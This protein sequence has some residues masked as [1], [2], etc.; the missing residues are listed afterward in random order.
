MKPN[1]ANRGHLS[2]ATVISLAAAAS[3][4]TLFAAA[5][6][7][8]GNLTP[9]NALKAFETEPGFAVTLVAA[10]PLTI[11][12]VALAFDERG[13]LFV[14]EGRDYP[15]GSPD[16]RP[17]GV[18][19]ML[20]D[21]DGDGR[22]DKRTDFATGIKFPN[23]VMCWRG[24]VIVTAAPDVWW[25]RDTND[26][27]KADVKELLLTGFDT[28]STSQLR[29]NDPT[30]G[31]DGWV[32]IAGGLRG[33]K[34]YSPKR[35]GVII[36][37]DKGDLRFKPDTGEMELTEGKSQFGL[38]FDD[39]GNRFAYMNRIQS[40]HAP[41]AFRYVARNP[42]LT[43]PG[44]LQSCPE[45][46]EN[47]LMTRY[48]AGA[49]RYYPI[50]D[51]LTTADSHFGTYSAACAVHVYRGDA[52]PEPYRGAAFSCDPTG[53][54]VRGDRLEK[55]GGTFAARRI[56]EG[57]EALRSR[58]NWFRPV[59]IA[60]GPDGALYIADMYRKVIEHP[61]YLP[62]DVRKHVDFE[63]G[64]DK[65]RI[66]KL[67]SISNTQR[68]TFKAIGSNVHALVAEL[69]S[70][71]PWRRD[72]AFRFLVERNDPSTAALLRKSLRASD[73]SG[74]AVVKLRLLEFAGAMDE[75]TLLLAL[76]HPQP[77]VRQNAVRIAEPSLARN[78]SLHDLVLKLADDPDPHVRFQV[79]LSLGEARSAE[80]VPALARIAA[81]QESDLWTRA[82]ILSALPARTNALA[83]LGELVRAGDPLPEGFIA[84][85]G[86]LGRQLAS[87]VETSKLLPAY[88]EIA[89]R[90]VSASG[91]LVIAANL[92]FANAAGP[93]FRRIAGADPTR[94][95]SLLTQSRSFATATNT[96]QELRVASVEL[97]AF[98]DSS[99][100]T[101]L[102][103]GLLGADHSREVQRAAARSLLQSSRVASFPA[104]L[105]AE[106]WNAY[107]P[108][109]RTMLL[110]RMAGGPE[111]APVL[112][113]AIEAG[114]VP[115]NAL[116][117][118]QRDQLRKSKNPE[119]KSRAEKL[120]AAP[121][122][123]RESAFNE[124][125]AA[126]KL[127]PVPSNGRTVFEK[128]CAACHRLNQQGVAVGPDLFDIRQQPKESIL[129]HIIIP[130][131]EIAPNF[132]NYE[133]E[134]KDGRTLSGLL[135][136]ENA[137]S[138]TLRMGQ[139]VEENVA[140]SQIAR[141]T[142]SRL[143]LM[144]QELEKTMTAQELAD[145]LAY[146]KGEQ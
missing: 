25:F 108:G 112:L 41:L 142:A 77:A 29:A 146:L 138:I 136:S 22:M 134:L 50:S 35:P 5:V 97:L 51:N 98:D 83:L 139:G 48:T 9:A 2:L 45:I 109:V 14:A 24:G 30:L 121:G 120:F 23:G 33:G 103:S 128:S 79:A 114:N 104:L 27:G 26:D 55:S 34:V 113:D 94:F 135:A 95:A 118:A 40:Q 92:G 90:L 31:P 13:R 42:F 93:E 140:R 64:K 86:D 85:A 119:L 144:P 106:R 127:S 53:N 57:T 126:L 1:R 74:P 102:L 84:L 58:D 76:K 70:P 132:V 71:I 28:N 129:Y 3:V 115:G 47:T 141:L 7:P 66:W 145:L 143:S 18:I 56:H 131:A 63:A 73:A 15:V 99:D 124:A 38:A 89:R 78:T 133:C 111:F 69:S 60:D 81:K 21:T 65:G 122:G 20:E 11:D 88:E 32:Y 101:P 125:K 52:L 67:T 37:T 116:T 72:T 91:G 16:G 62:G 123:N 46:S 87:G 130:E 68:P 49:A 80:L 39:A 17:L 137:G 96:S 61:E 36:D 43:S 59:F 110:D 107:T 100:A 4:H 10:E 54:L 19:A 6:T 82:A 105:T 75:P 117:S 44:V 8:L 12:P